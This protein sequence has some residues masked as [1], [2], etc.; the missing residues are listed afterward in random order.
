MAVRE[1]LR[2]PYGVTLAAA[3]AGFGFFLMV[4]ETFGGFQPE[5]QNVS[6]HV[7]KALAGLALSVSGGI[8]LTIGPEN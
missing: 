8:A 1:F 2:S 7:V 6:G 4:T 5:E 3:G